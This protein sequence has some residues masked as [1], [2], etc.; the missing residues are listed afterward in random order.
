MTNARPIAFNTIACVALCFA[1]PLFSARTAC[2]ADDAVSAAKAAVLGAMPDRRPSGRDQAPHRCPP[3]TSSLF[4]SL[5]TSRTTS[6][7]STGC[8]LKSP[9]TFFGQTATRRKSVFSWF[10]RHV[11]VSI[12]GVLILLYILFE[13]VTQVFVK[14][15]V[16]ALAI[17]STQNW[18]VVANLP[19][20][21]LAGLSVGQKVWFMIGSDP[22][23][24][25]AGQKHRTRRSSISGGFRTT[26]LCCANNR[27]A[28]CR[29]Y[30]YLYAAESPSGADKTGAGI[31]KTRHL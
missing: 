18:R 9:F 2:A 25:H 26:P 28:G 21:H 6:R 3:R 20:R 11:V 12:C 22:W 7:A 15:G 1:G 23:R 30:R 8:G 27:L 17:V 29:Y 13:L 4:T 16:L 24:F 19:E 14:T 5:E 10:K 31:E